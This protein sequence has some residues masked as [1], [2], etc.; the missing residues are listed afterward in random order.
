MEFGPLSLHG[1][2]LLLLVGA[3]AGLQLSRTLAWHRG[4]TADV[5]VDVA[6]W[7][8]AAAL[9]GARLWYVAFRWH[10]VYR[11]APVE[12]LMPW[13]GG[14]AIHGGVVGGVLACIFI[15]RHHGLGTL[16]LLDL[17]APGLLLGQVIGRWGNYLNQEAYGL[18]ALA[19]GHWPAWLRDGTGYLPWGIVIDAGRRVPPFDD[20]L[21]WPATTRFH[22]TFL[23]ESFWNLFGLLGLMHVAFRHKTQNG[24]VAGLYLIVWGTGRLWIEALRTDALLLPLPWAT[25]KVAQVASLVVLALGIWLVLRGRGNVSAPPLEEI[26][27]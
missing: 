18:P 2:S 8:S 1:Y 5:L 21:V 3:L 26:P 23:Y 20:M 13:R 9:V 10:D 27:A 24:T 12:A 7:G 17:V 16:R 25:L 22:P 11:L 19:P 15:A 6:V 4:I 14:L